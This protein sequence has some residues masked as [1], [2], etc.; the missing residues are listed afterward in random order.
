M[1]KGD[2]GVK[3]WISILTAV[4]LLLSVSPVFAAGC[5]DIEGNPNEEYIQRLLDKGILTTDGGAFYPEN[6][7]TRAEFLD[8]CVKTANW[9]T[10]GYH[11]AYTDVRKSDAYAASIQ[12]AHDKGIVPNAMLDEKN[13]EPDRPLVR[14]EA[15]VILVQLFGKLC[16]Y[17]VAELSAEAFRDRL[18]ISSWAVSAVES[19]LE[20]GFLDPAAAGTAA[21][22]TRVTRGESAKM[23]CMILEK[24][25]TVDRTAL[26][27]D[28]IPVDSPKE[29]TGIIKW[30]S[31]FGVTPENPDNYP[32]MCEALSY[33]R[34]NKVYKL[35]VPKGIYYF[36]TAAP[37]PVENMEDFI[38]DGQGSDF[39]FG[40][41]ER[42]TSAN[43]N[44]INIQNCK[45]VIVRNFTMDWDWETERLASLGV[46]VSEQLDG[47][48][49]EMEFPEVEYMPEEQVDQKFRRVTSYDSKNYK[50]GVPD[51]MEDG[52]HNG[53]YTVE[54]RTGPNRFIISAPS[55]SSAAF[56]KTKGS[57][58]LIRH[59][60]YEFHGMGV[61]ASQHVTIDG[62]SIFSAAGHGLAI[63]GGS[64]YWQFI[65]GRITIKPGSGRHISTNTDGMHIGSP[66]GY[67]KV[68]NCQ[69]SYHG[70][71]ATNAYRYLTNAYTRNQNKKNAIDITYPTWQYPLSVGD[72]IE[73][74]NDDMSESGFR[75]VTTLVQDNGENYYVEFDRELPDDLP[76]GLVMKNNTYSAAHYVFRNNVFSN[77][78]ARGSLLHEGYALVEGNIYHGHMNSNVF[79]T[80]GIGRWGEGFDMDNTIFR[81]NILSEPNAM[82]SGGS[83]AAIDFQLTLP[84]GGVTDYPAYRNILIEGN[85]FIEPVPAAVSVYAAKNV[86]IRDNTI[87]AETQVPYGAAERGA[88]KVR[89]SSEVAVSG[90]RWIKSDIFADDG[91]IQ[92]I[93]QPT[94]QKCA[95]KD[96]VLV[97]DDAAVA[98]AKEAVAAGIK[99]PGSA[100]AAAK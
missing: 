2:I 37:I 51:G 95:A 75:A 25:S 56:Y 49:F 53:V 74:R 9:Q 40:G 11:C 3:R 66:G 57:E 81:N 69:I 31:E 65:N 58:F 70:D 39:I 88:I 80:N 29:G 67:Y 8:F 42:L 94:A 7:I 38:L 79:F 48:S 82:L 26:I 99:L 61:S 13:L 100:Y 93:F 33:C 54:K 59:Y 16:G 20:F 63:G 60:E 35:L 1:E 72:E 32:A 92:I 71:D 34:E 6:N 55:A 18:D 23:M 91:D 86:K 50:I 27:W 68:E 76:D 4:F 44:Y 30:A 64:S 24:Q 28:D 97:R 78:R 47:N 85:R 17:K 77:N 14:E 21:P 41:R 89:N 90:N 73:F 83:L 96:N 19:A 5:T 45:R 36:A 15:A 52:I 12:T 98:A 87:M 10:D 46:V 22:K 43:L 84:S 62:V